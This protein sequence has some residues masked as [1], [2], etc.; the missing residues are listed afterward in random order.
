MSGKISMCGVGQV[1]Q[2]SRRTGFTKISRGSLIISCICNITILWLCVVSRNN[3]CFVYFFSGEGL[4]N[5]QSIITTS[6]SA[7]STAK[8]RTFSGESSE[9]RTMFAR[10]CPY[11]IRKRKFAAK[12]RN[13]IITSRND[14]KP[15]TFY[16]VNTFI[17]GEGIYQLQGKG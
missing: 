15:F 12:I 6:T 1:F 2:W 17:D 5:T 10:K 8:I 16:E 11:E 9:I 13:A 14:W 4:W 3:N 7:G